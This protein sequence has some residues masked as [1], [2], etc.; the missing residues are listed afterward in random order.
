MLAP[1]KSSSARNR[2][3]ASSCDCPAAEPLSTVIA[4]SNMERRKF[5]DMLKSI[6]A[7]GAFLMLMSL[8]KLGNA[9]ELSPADQR[10]KGTIF[11]EIDLTSQQEIMIDSLFV[12]Y[13]SELNAIDVRIDSLESD[14]NLSEDQLLVRIT[15]L[16]QEKKDLKEV[17]ELDIKAALQP[18]QVTLYD[19]K[20]APK[21]PKVL[22]FG[23]HN[24][25]DCNVCDK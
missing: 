23:I 13:A 10:K 16:N 2:W 11:K 12:V 8:P 25:A 19:E 15:V 14:A 17:R 24:R 1:F 18:E 3:M 20:V 21:K 22:H 7:I 5:E 9:Q 4:V 6:L